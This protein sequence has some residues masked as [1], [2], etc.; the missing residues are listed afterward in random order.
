[1]SFFVENQFQLKLENKLI[2]ESVTTLSAWEAQSFRRWLASPVFNTRSGLV[3]L[4]DYLHATWLKGNTADANEAYRVFSGE[5]GLD[6]KQ[7]R[8]ALSWLQGQLRQFAAWQE[9]QS[10]PSVLSMAALKHFRKREMGGNFKKTKR[11]IEQ[12]STRAEQRSIDDFLLNFQL[13]LE[14]YQWDLAQNRAQLLP[15]EALS[16]QLYAYYVAKMLQLGCMFRAQEALQKQ[17]RS[18]L[19]AVE[20]IISTLP[21]SMVQSLPEVALYYYGY[22]MLTHSEEQHWPQQFTAYLQQYG[23]QFPV[24]DARELLLM[25]VNHCIRR[26]NLG[27]KEAIR[28]ILKLYE[29]GLEQKLFHDERRHLSQYTYNNILMAIIAQEDWKRAEQ[30]LEEYKDQ[31]APAHQEAVY[32][33]NRAVFL[34][35]RGDYEDAQVLLRELRFNDPR[36]NLEARRMLLRIYYESGAFDALESLLENL[37]TWVRRHS[38]IGYHRE[39]YRNLARFTGKLLKLAPSDKDRRK[40]LARKIRE[41]PLVADREW[42]LSKLK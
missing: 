1:M 41:T 9:I 12:Q 6:E 16:Q 11:E 30:F 35:R 21:D 29:L 34:F 24:Q 27:D 33:Y 38:E 18:A 17:P 37:L 2:F 13:H 23:R 40:R 8:Y 15:F 42:L 10:V 20:T 22:Q 26:I 36:Y 4:F 32:R 19:P 39:M 7:L 5:P 25:A 31:L 14:Q 3:P 28:Q